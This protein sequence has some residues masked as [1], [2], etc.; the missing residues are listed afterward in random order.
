[1][2]RSIWVFAAAA[3]LL[4]GGAWGVE[5]STA[6]LAGKPVTVCRVNVKEERLQLFPRD[7]AGQPLKSFEG[8]NRWLFK[9]GQKL[10]SG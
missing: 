3:L 8:I 9:R 7:D 6:T 1:M 10:V 2:L 4:P 5:F